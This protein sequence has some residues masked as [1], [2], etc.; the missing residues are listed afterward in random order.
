MILIAPLNQKSHRWKSSQKK[1]DNV[2][3][4]LE[5]GIIPFLWKKIVKKI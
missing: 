4:K 2:R 1:Y 3:C 5:M